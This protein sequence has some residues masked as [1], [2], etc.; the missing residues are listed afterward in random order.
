MKKTTSAK[1]RQETDRV[2][3]PSL[4]EQLD[5]ANEW[6]EECRVAINNERQKFE[7]DLATARQ[8][9]M[10]WF[11]MCYNYKFH[12]TALNVAASGAT[13]ELLQNLETATMDMLMAPSE[14]DSRPTRSFHQ[15]QIRHRV[16]FGAPQHPMAVEAWY[17]DAVGTQIVGKK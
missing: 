4:Q 11:W 7:S 2:K 14:P 3:E 10:F 8:E 15:D 5:Q 1:S 12:H 17:A 16:I 13:A 9:R 6:L